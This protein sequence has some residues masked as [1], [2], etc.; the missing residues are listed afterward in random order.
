MINISKKI[1]IFASIIFVV[2]IMVK[3]F[4]PEVVFE[5]LFKFDTYSSGSGRDVLWSTAIDLFKEKPFLG[6]GWGGTPPTQHNTYL[7][8]LTEIGIVGTMMFLVSIGWICFRSIYSKRPLAIVIIIAGLA[9]SFFIEAINKR[10]FWN[11]IILAAM[12]ILSASD[13]SKKT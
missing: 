5:R 6:W 7:N 11:A 8:M 2:F 1:I 10:F 4:I 3:Y 12:L 9:P 13:A